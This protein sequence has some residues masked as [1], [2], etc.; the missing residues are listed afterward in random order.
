[1]V[2]TRASPFRPY[3]ASFCVAGRDL[4][5]QADFPLRSSCLRVSL[6]LPWSESS[7]NICYRRTD[8][9]IMPDPLSAAGLVVGAASL[10][11]QIFEGCVK[12]YRY[13]ESA[14]NMP[15]ECAS[16]KTRIMIEYGRLQDWGE[17]TGLSDGQKHG[18][19]DRRMKI[20][21][22][23]IEAVL[24]EI[25]SELKM[26]SKA[27]LKRAELQVSDGK[28]FEN[29]PTDSQI[30]SLP[31]GNVSKV[32][33]GT[34]ITATLETSGHHDPLVEACG[35]AAHEVARP[36][37]SRE[38]IE[39]LDLHKFEKIFDS[40]YIPQEKRR[41]PKGLNGIVGLVKAAGSVVAHSKRMKWAMNDKQ[42]VTTCLERLKKLTDYLH[43]TLDETQMQVLLET[44]RETWL[45]MLQ[46]NNS[47]TEMSELLKAMQADDGK[48]ES[49]QAT[50]LS[51]GG[52]TLVGSADAANAQEPMI[53]EPRAFYE[54]LTFFSIAAAKQLELQ[55]AGQAESR[56]EML[57]STIIP[58]ADIV[59][60]K[61]TATDWNGVGRTFA[62]MSDRKVWIEWKPYNEVRVPDGEGRTKRGPDP[63]I[64]R[65]VERLVALLRIPNRPVEF[66]VPNCNG[67]FIQQDKRCFGIVYEFRQLNNEATGPASLF[68][69]LRQ[70][71]PS[72]RDRLSIA[73]QLVR[74]IMYLHAVNWLHKG[75]KSSNVLFAL[76]ET[77]DYTGL[78]ISG[79][80]Y[81]RPDEAGLTNT[82]PVEDLSWGEYLPPGYLGVTNRKKGYR[83]TYDIYSLGIILLEI[84]HWKPAETILGFE[85]C[86]S[87]IHQ[88][89]DAK[90][91]DDVKPALLP[92]KL[93]NLL[94][95]R[96]RLVNETSEEL[97]QVKRT[98]GDRYHAALR[99]CLVGMEAFGLSDTLPQSDPAVAALLQQAFM[100]IVI[101]VLEGIAV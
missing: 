9:V 30:E 23:V 32:G 101:D 41:Y 85:P 2:E 69:L 71:S 37:F 67:Y 43:E 40:P 65:N 88:G 21:A 84:A 58:D 66:C 82:A 92:K 6:S 42:K 4:P 87:V 93:P 59:T 73:Q 94:K 48:S 12:G 100:R 99:A 57:E 25:R 80:E 7:N 8:L 20:N 74:S 77:G 3:T 15:A 52:S 83:K 14:V 68:N 34:D 1:M 45:A 39:S 63:Y 98:M 38:A 27:S 17:A 78:Y 5:L 91:K 61:Q 13:F 76:S 53:H 24:T 47:V 31:P 62:S 64:A 79:L 44:T 89:P 19:Y 33:K 28:L 56:A 72:L 11:I 50:V 46:M 96:D 16:I 22:A 10:S 81:S 29:I 26:L 35:D 54:R 90:P 97:H 18:Q 36:H 75:L 95:I 49:D 51:W 86:M 55:E 60:L 70:E